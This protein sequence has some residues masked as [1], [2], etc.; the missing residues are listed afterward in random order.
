[1]LMPTS[2]FLG[3]VWEL[4]I[5]GSAPAQ[6]NQDHS[7]FGSLSSY[8]SCPPSCSWYHFPTAVRFGSEAAP[9]LPR[10]RQKRL[11]GSSRKCLVQTRSCTLLLQRQEAKW[12]DPSCFLLQDSCS[13]CRCLVGKVTPNGSLSSEL[14]PGWQLGSQWAVCA[15]CAVPGFPVPACQWGCRVSTGIWLTLALQS[16]L[17]EGL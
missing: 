15:L 11:S 4:P 2:H 7:D 16:R 14:S 3:Q 13:P 6:H 17:E 12:R 5:C 10:A 8:F 9:A 1:M